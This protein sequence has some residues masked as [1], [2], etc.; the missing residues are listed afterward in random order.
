MASAQLQYCAGSYMASQKNAYAACSH[1]V[2]TDSLTMYTHTV[3]TPV[4]VCSSL[5]GL[6]DRLELLLVLVLCFAALHC[7]HRCRERY[8]I[9]Y[10]T[11]SH[12]ASHKNG[13]R[14]LSRGVHRVADNVHKRAYTSCCCWCAYAGCIPFAKTRCRFLSARSVARSCK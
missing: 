4:S 14:L 1:A 8:S 5:L 7:G 2:L 11:G 6:H 3:P 10:C 13:Y 9:Q 12:T